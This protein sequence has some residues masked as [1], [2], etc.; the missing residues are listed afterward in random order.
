M[1]RVSERTPPYISPHAQIAEQ[2]RDTVLMTVARIQERPHGEVRTPRLSATGHCLRQ[3]YYEITGAS[4]NAIDASNPWELSD[5]NLHEGDIKTYLRLSGFRVRDEQDEVA[6]FLEDGSAVKGHPDGIV[7]TDI[8]GYDKMVLECKS[9]GFLGYRD[10]CLKGIRAA[11]PGYYQQIQSY[12]AALRVLRGIFVVKAKD[13]GAVRRSLSGTS[14]HAKLYIEIVDADQ[15]VVDGVRAR[16]LKLRGALDTLTPPDP[17]YKP[18]DWQCRWCRYREVC[19]PVLP[20]TDFGELTLLRAW[21][22]D[23]DT[24]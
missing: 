2:I 15:D 1:P 13:S 7:E 3:Q 21:E 4:E 22:P 24:P 20:K 14:H 6:L 8:F 9:A 23:E 18:A 10:I 11:Q 19:R 17:E 5:G 12:M 16:H